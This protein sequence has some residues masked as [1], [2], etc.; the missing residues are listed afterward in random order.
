MLENFKLD[1]IRRNTVNDL[2]D[3]AALA[4][5][6]LGKAKNHHMDK[7][8]LDFSRDLFIAVALELAYTKDNATFVDML[9]F[10]VSPD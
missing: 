4:A 1:C 9:N 6:I 2:S 10:I 8:S 5:R 3:A 7:A